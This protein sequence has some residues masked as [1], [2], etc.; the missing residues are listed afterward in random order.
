MVDEAGN[1]GPSLGDE[2]TRDTK[3]PDDSTTT[4]TVDTVAGDDNKVDPVEA[5][6]ATQA[7]TGQVT[8]EFKEGDAVVIKVG[9][10]VIGNGT[11]NAD[12]SFSVNVPTEKLTNAADKKV[13]ATV[14]ATDPAGNTGDV[15]SA[16]KPYTVDLGRTA[17]T[18]TI[19]T[20]EDKPYN[21][22]VEYITKDEI[23]PATES[24]VEKVSVSVAIPDDAKAGDTLTLTTNT[25]AAPI[26]YRVQA[27]D[28]G[29]TVTQSVT[30]PADGAE[31]TVSAT[32][33]AVDNANTVSATGEAKATRD[34]SA[35]IEITIGGPDYF[36]EHPD[37]DP[38]G[39][40]VPVIV[41]EDRQTMSSLT[42]REIRDVEEVL[43][44]GEVNQEGNV[45]VTFTLPSDAK[46]GDTLIYKVDAGGKRKVEYNDEGQL[47]FG[48][49]TSE[50]TYHSGE[51]KVLT[52]SD[53][54]AGKVE[55]Y[56]WAP[57]MGGQTIDVTASL[58][59][60]LG[61]KGEDVQ[62]SLRERT[63]VSK[64]EVDLVG[65]PAELELSVSA[66]TETE[67]E[68]K[69]LATAYEGVADSQL[70]YTVS[71]NKPAQK[72]YKVAIKLSGNGIT[73]DEYTVEGATA[74]W[75][76][77]GITTADGADVA[78]E[79]SIVVVTISKGDSAARFTLT[80]K[81]D[82][83]AEGTEVVTAEVVPTVFKF[84]IDEGKV[85]G[86]G[87]FYTLGDKTVAEGAITEVTPPTVSIAVEG[88][89]TE[90]VSYPATEEDADTTTV[91]TYTV[92]LDGAQ[93]TDT[94]VKVKLH[95]KATA[96]DYNVAG[97]TIVSQKEVQETI[98][99]GESGSSEL[100]T[101]TYKEI[102]VKVPAGQTSVT[103]TVD[104]IREEEG[105]NFNFEGSETVVATIQTDADNKYEV[106][107]V[108]ADTNTGGQ[109]IGLI[110]DAS[111]I[112]LPHLN[113]DISLAYG[114]SAAHLERTWNKT[115]AVSNTAKTVSTVPGKDS[116]GLYK[117]YGDA[118]VMTDRADNLN[119]GYYANGEASGTQ[120]NFANFAD[121]GSS[122]NKTD[123]NQSLSTIDTGKGDDMVRIKGA[124][125]A[126]TRLYLGEGNDTYELGNFEKAF[127]DKER[128]GNFGA[129][130]ALKDTYIFAESGNDTIKIGGHSNGYL[131]AG[132][133]SDTVTIDGIA[134][135][136]IDL[137]SGR[138][139]PSEYLTKY[140]DGSDRSLGNDTNVDSAT[141]E[142]RLTIEGNG[143][144]A[145][146][147]HTSNIYGGEGKDIIE[148]KK[149]WYA[150]SAHM[151]L[152][153][154]DNVVTI[155][156]GVGANA[157]ITTGSGNDTVSVTGEHRGTMNLG[158]GVNTVSVGGAASGNINAG[159][160]NDTVTVTGAF[161]GIMNLDDGRNV[162]SIGGGNG[163]IT[164]TNGDD[165]F[166]SN[167]RYTGNVNLGDGTN[168]I[169]IDGD[170]VR[171]PLNVAARKSMTVGSGDDEITITGEFGANDI[172]LGDGQN[173]LSIGGAASGNINAGSGDD[174]VDITGVF[175]GT[176]DLGDGTNTA[177]VGGNFSGTYNGGAGSDTLNVGGNFTGTFNGGNGDDTIQVAG[178]VGGTIN[179][180]DGN[181]KL[182]VTGAGSTIDFTSVINVK[183]IDLT[184]AGRQNVDIK[185]SDLTNGS[186]TLKAIY[187]KGTNEDT[188]DL[189]DNNSSNL[190]ANLNDNSN[191]L[192]NL[193][194]LG[195]WS[196]KESGKDV[197][198]VSYDVYQYS[199]R[200]GTSDE[201]VY[202]QQGVQVI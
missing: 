116:A 36:A 55:V 49:T 201:L 183:D 143:T 194:G 63:T 185:L 46:V 1:E 154:G 192:T 156:E 198:G 103:F 60:L 155:A 141:D 41:S 75:Y 140:Q 118:I 122:G 164:T 161:S 95:G 19:G 98:D 16:E 147:S 82:N 130:A 180:G 13:T 9:D 94:V 5:K 59:D 157:V 134:N 33:T 111:P 133:G 107:P 189:G 40:Y 77:D 67:V 200:N 184:A 110:L 21:N 100:V 112:A 39:P 127:N 138:A 52:A 191:G 115:L 196:V 84:G 153:N 168:V 71:L 31:L 8:G 57:N 175:S 146:V 58:T 65:D 199:N 42:G 195:S 172:N 96:G 35:K 62:F 64:G 44:S 160:G 69:N 97:A 173:T 51:S 85:G 125:I 162:I 170:Y 32:I 24:T 135:G 50:H 120:G 89:I 126:G 38:D 29:K 12:G 136:D 149:G 178:N 193:L 2:A 104:P 76:K 197:D 6:Q 142:N 101:L 109:A 81:A 150:G 93:P 169:H 73:T 190:S 131:Y 7:V 128:R 114:E 68:G 70:T 158:D 15:V 102:E 56:V 182:I 30:A 28:I 17:P 152:G 27:G 187:I 123:N 148:I 43:Y 92:K 167:G 108:D 144:S 23:E 37:S 166:T 117:D 3:A 87:N 106:A 186:D 20:K 129:T 113:G 179:G 188:V 88:N 137:G 145:T 171:N 181:N 45:R 177:T 163:D 202:I 176:M 47:I 66:N 61:N 90:D 22:G 80:P 124:Q 18:V 54:D 86:N 121:S 91:L 34:T 26:T 99:V 25:D 53:I 174:K 74:Q 105:A 48:E 165:S 10:E 72:D 78:A 139:M 132:S 151:E 11:V 14:T 79:G 119:I 83:V 4:V 159:S